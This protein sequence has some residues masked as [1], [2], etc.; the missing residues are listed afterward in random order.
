[1]S[2]LVKIKKIE[3]LTHDV[4]RVVTEKPESLNYQPGQAADISLNIEG[5]EQ[6]LRA[7]TFVS[8][9]GDDYVEFNII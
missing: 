9:P 1:M 7:F 5:W 4:L 2:K 6:E 8:L 3:H